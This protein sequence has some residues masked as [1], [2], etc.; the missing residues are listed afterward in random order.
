MLF[1][2][3]FFIISFLITH[4][5][6]AIPLG[7]V[8]PTKQNTQEAGFLLTESLS[9]YYENIVDQVMLDLTEDVLSF[10]PE[11]ISHGDVEVRQSSQ[12]SMNRNLNFM[13]ASLLASINPLV[14]T[15]IPQVHGFDIIQDKYTKAANTEQQEL[16]SILSDAILTLNKKISHQLGL[17]VNAEQ[18]SSILIRQ[19]STQ[20]T[21]SQAANVEKPTVITVEWKLR[22][23][24][25]IN[26]FRERRSAASTIENDALESEWLFS[27]LSSVEINLLNE[28]NDRVEEAIQVVMETLSFDI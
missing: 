3:L 4:V 9:E 25:Q 14:S 22:R 27:Q 15:D 1:T 16:E 21:R 18:S 12:K 11:S 2:H 6:K 10:L 13:R 17:I 20:L 23:P 7:N 5:V 26:V 19:A 8:P 24:F 28:F